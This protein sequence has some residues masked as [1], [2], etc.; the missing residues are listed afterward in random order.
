MCQQRASITGSRARP[1]PKEV[2]VGKSLSSHGRKE[3]APWL[4]PSISHLSVSRC[5]PT[6]TPVPFLLCVCVCVMMERRGEKVD[7]APQRAHAV[8]GPPPVDAGRHCALRCSLTRCPS[9]P[10]LVQKVTR[11][12]TPDPPAGAGAG[13]AWFVCFFIIVRENI[14]IHKIHQ[15][16]L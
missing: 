16:R 13:S 6:Y 8:L 9:S 4:S 14:S 15:T 7:R 3:I 12:S 10:L 5:S 2:R 11:D 1:R